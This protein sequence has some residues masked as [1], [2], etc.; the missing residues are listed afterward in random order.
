MLHWAHHIARTEMDIP[1]YLV[2]TFEEEKAR[3]G[4]TY[5]TAEVSR[6]YSRLA[7][8]MG[9]LCLL[10]ED[11]R[12]DESRDNL[13]GIFDATLKALSPNIPPTAEQTVSLSREF[14]GLQV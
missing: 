7:N 8:S 3:V 11:S 5:T 2:G 14:L 4:S 12:K 1:E 9:L 6:A 10:L 13:R